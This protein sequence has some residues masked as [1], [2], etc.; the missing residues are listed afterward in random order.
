MD[1][2]KF[3]H[4]RRRPIASLVAV[5]CCFASGVVWP[6]AVQGPGSADELLD[7]FVADVRDLSAGFEQQ[8]FDQNGIPVEELSTG[9]FALLRPDLFRWH[10]AAP[11]EQIIVA[12][13]EW[14]WFYDVQLEQADR[15]PKSDLATSPAMLLSG[16]ATLR[17]SYDI[18]ELS[19]AD[20]KRWL[21]L[22]PIDPAANEFV[23]ARLGFA[24]G[25]PVVLELVDGLNELTRIAFA[26]IE[27]N[28]GLTSDD[29][30]FVP[31]AGVTIVGADD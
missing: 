10:Y 18:S 27:V 1:F 9:R 12:D 5:L 16:A 25:V 31:P 7:A 15:R 22:T 11:D 2:V 8:R 19:P 6:Q 29:F 3:S 24:G 14:L 13:G 28:T 4:R 23:V 26:A 21:E 17:D 30:A 20:G